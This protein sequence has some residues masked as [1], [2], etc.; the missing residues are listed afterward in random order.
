M[1]A[2]SV[3][4]DKVALVRNS[5]GENRP[6]LAEAARTVIE[7]GANGLTIHPRA[8]RRH[9]LIEDIAALMALDPV[10]GGRVE[11]NIEGDLRGDLMNA[12]K[13]AG[14][15]Q[16]TVVPVTEGEVTSNR[17]WTKA[18]GEAPLRDAVRFFDH[19]LRVSVFVDA[20][21]EGVRL[22]AEC[23]ADAVEFYTGH[24]ARAFA[25]PDR[26]RRL[27]EIVAATGLARSLGLRVHAGHD[28]DRANLPP[29]LAAINPDEVSIGHAV[30]S[31][32]IL[33]GLRDAA[34][35]Y[36]RVIGAGR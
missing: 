1:T 13:A 19:K 15:H 28:L 6:D 31:D 20:A 17:G 32:A 36:L 7:A 12:A 16:F 24:Y 25:T 2:F 22:A 3:N 21:E 29:L 10:R 33:A 5:R 18:D 4:L 8:D 9:A 27:D 26:Q 11:L 30:I 34:A 14:A 23:G 35:D